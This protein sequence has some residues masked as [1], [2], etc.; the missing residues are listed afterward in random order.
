MKIVKQME[1]QL[2]LT[3]TPEKNSPPL[4]EGWPTQSDGVVKNPAPLKEGCPTQPGGVVQKGGITQKESPTSPT[5]KHLE[6]HSGKT[7]P[8]QRRDFGP[9]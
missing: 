5:L 2:G 6:K 9:Y 4:E 1:E 7:S 8:R 3:F